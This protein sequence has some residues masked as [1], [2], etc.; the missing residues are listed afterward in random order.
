M[1]TI[2][3]L[4]QSKAHRQTHQLLLKSRQHPPSQSSLDVL[5]MG[6]IQHS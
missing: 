2:Y 1:V 4:P 3:S 5:P 6:C